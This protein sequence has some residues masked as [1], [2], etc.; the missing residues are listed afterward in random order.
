MIKFLIGNVT[1]RPASVPLQLDLLQSELAGLAEKRD[2]ANIG[3]NIANSSNIV[4]SNIGSSNIGSSSSNK[5]SK[6]G[7]TKKISLPASVSGTKDL[8]GSTSKKVT[9]KFRYLVEHSI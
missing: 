3:S 9:I 7:R 6:E 4:S 2:N 1:P 8:G 5:P